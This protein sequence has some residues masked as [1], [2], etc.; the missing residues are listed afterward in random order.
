MTLRRVTLALAIGAALLGAGHTALTPFE[1]PGWTRTGL[2]F[3]GT[4]LAMMTAA[5][6]NIVGLGS[7][8]SPTL[9]L[10][11]LVDMAMT[12]FSSPLGPWCA[13]RQ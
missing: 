13:G 4:G 5:A 1:Y 8:R 2:W 3:V 10:I 12:A 7:P 11:I 6:I 9:W